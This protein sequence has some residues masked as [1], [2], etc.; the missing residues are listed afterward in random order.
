MMIL[1]FVAAVFLAWPTA[2]LSIVAFL[3]FAFVRMHFKVKARMHH[4]D[5]AVARRQMERS[6]SLAVPKWARD[7]SER[8]VFI[9][10]VVKVAKHRGV[11]EMFSMGFLN[12]E[13]SVREVINL[14]GQMERQGASFTSQQLATTN[15]IEQA[16]NRLGADEQQRVKEAA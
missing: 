1:L 15:L 7:E 3:I 5:E 8:E 10:S 13:I 16:W 4:A 9:Y 2:G 11:P 12:S 6:D 14:A